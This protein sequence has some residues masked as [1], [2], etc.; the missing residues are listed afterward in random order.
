M[1]MVDVDFTRFMGGFLG[2]WMVVLWAVVVGF[3][4]SVGAGFYLLIYKYMVEVIFHVI[5]K[6][7]MLE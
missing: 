1:K 7:C 3:E 2:L 4:G 6:C 5:L